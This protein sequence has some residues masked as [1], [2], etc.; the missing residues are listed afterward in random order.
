MRL[1]VI[2]RE[3]GTNYVMGTEATDG[4][5][6]RTLDIHKAKVFLMR[7]RPDTLATPAVG[8][9]PVTTGKIL[10]DLDPPLPA[11]ITGEWELA[12]V[13]LYLTTPNKV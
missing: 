12:Q 5:A 3:R 7:V 2:C 8:G 4:Y 6:N 13:E 10:V 11:G 1:F 9:S